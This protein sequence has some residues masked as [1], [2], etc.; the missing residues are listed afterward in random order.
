M[1]REQIVKY[2]ALRARR[3]QLA[4]FIAISDFAFTNDAVTLYAAVEM[5]KNTIVEIDKEIESL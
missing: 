5:A 1:T 4:N 3:E 2:N